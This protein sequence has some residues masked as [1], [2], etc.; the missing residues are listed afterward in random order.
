MKQAIIETVLTLENDVYTTDQET[1]GVDGS[2]CEGVMHVIDVGES[3]DTLSG[4]VKVEL[5]IE[6]SDDNVTFAPVT[7]ASHVVD[8]TDSAYT[9]AAGI[10]AVIDSAADDVV[11]PSIHYVGPKRYSRVN[12]DFTGTH[13]NG[14][15]IGGLAIKSMLRKFP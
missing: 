15:P 13:N 11:V 8:G 3:N 1:A 2:G 7:D 5:I 9:A 14:I 6:D 12:A 4:S 10:F